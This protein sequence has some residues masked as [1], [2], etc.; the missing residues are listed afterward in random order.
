MLIRLSLT[1]CLNQDRYVLKNQI[2]IFNSYISP[3]FPLPTV[4]PI[5]DNLNF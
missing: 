3:Q 1:T 5:F 4:D 2:I